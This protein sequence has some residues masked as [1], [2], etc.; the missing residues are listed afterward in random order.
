MIFF[1]VGLKSLLSLF[2]LY[3]IF[4][5]WKLSR[6]SPQKQVLKSNDDGSNTKLVYFET[7]LQMSRLSEYQGYYQRGKTIPI[8]QYLPTQITTMLC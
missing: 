3:F 6:F 2:Q 5:N 7:P 8:A 4:K 1:L